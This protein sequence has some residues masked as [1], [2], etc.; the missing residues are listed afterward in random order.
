MDLKSYLEARGVR[1]ADFA[2]RVGTTPATV[3]R[4]IA[5][6]FRP[7]LDLAHRIERET[8]GAVPTEA[9]L[10]HRAAPATPSSPEKQQ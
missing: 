9:W 5:G 10:A 8:G 7:A 4:L 3:S 1:Q 2:E 6:I